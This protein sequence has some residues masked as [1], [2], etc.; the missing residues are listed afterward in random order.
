MSLGSNAVSCQLLDAETMCTTRMKL[1]EY[2][3]KEVGKKM[4][5]RSLGDIELQVATNVQGLGPKHP[6]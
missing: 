4:P 3:V 5:Q 1:A 2:K 6:A